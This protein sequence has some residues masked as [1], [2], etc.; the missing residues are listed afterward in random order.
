MIEDAQIRSNI[1]P[2]WVSYIFVGNIEVMTVD[3]FFQ[4]L[5]SLVVGEA[6]SECWNKGIPTFKQL[7]ICLCLAKGDLF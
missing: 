2:M 5:G 1:S 7:D 6:S 3:L 4:E